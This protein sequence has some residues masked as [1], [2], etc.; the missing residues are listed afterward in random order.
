VLQTT[1]GASRLLAFWLEPVS[2]FG[3]SEVTAPSAVHLCWTYHSAWP[4]HHLDAGSGRER[5]TAFFFVRR[6]RYVVSTAFDPAVTSYADVD[7]LLRTEPQVQLTPFVLNNHSNSFKSHGRSFPQRPLQVHSCV[8]RKAKE[9]KPAEGLRPWRATRGNPQS[10]ALRLCRPPLRYGP[11][12]PLRPLHSANRSVP[13][14]GNP[15]SCTC[16]PCWRGPGPRRVCEQT[17][18]NHSR[19]K[20]QQT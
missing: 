16:R 12:T 6:Q 15:S 3:S 13:R 8:P 19:A 2:V 20:E 11:S 14:V 4:S 18:P 17:Q 10:S 9:T 5:L 1:G 7:R